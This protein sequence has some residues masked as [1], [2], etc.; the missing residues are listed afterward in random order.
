MIISREL[1]IDY[2]RDTMHV[3]STSEAKSR[4]MGIG[5][6]WWVGRQIGR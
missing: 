1:G 4:T 2:L 3:A 6:E 5:R